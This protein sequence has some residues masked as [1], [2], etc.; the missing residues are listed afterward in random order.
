MAALLLESNEGKDVNILEEI[1]QNLCNHEETPLTIFMH[2]NGLNDMCQL[3]LSSKLS[4]ANL[5]DLESSDLKQLCESLYF[6]VPQQIRLKQAVKKLQEKKQQIDNNEEKEN[7]NN[8]NNLSLK[9]LKQLKQF[10]RFEYKTVILGDSRVG[11]SSIVIK[12]I[13]DE[14]DQYKFPTIG[15]TFLTHGIWLNEELKAV[16][17]VWD[18]AGQEK[19]RNLAPLYY[20]RTYAVIVVYDI[21]NRYSFENAKKWIEEVWEMEGTHVKVILLGNKSDLYEDR[22]V[23]LQEALHWAT[24]NSISFIETS[25]KL[26][27][28]FDAINKWLKQ[29]SQAKWDADGKDIMERKKQNVNLNVVIAPKDDQQA[30]KCC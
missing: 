27:T 17:A 4:L 19:Y 12:L 16:I 8:N 3:L 20:K 28:N 26:G 21:T 1:K 5:E 23:T 10:A 2:D 25:A 9:Q 6:T 11:K 24:S 7:L 29:Q 13:K 22:K 18:T 14:F 30:K 15:A